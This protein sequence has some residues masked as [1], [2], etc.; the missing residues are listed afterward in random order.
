MTTLISFI[1][2]VWNL[3]SEFILHMDRHLNEWVGIMGPWF[4]LLVFV[5]VFCETGLVVTPFLPG[6]SLFFALGA[7]TSVEDARLS[8][9]LLYVLAPVAAIIGNAVNYSIGNFLGPRVFRREA[10]E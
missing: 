4:Y 1:A 2:D 6:D 8:L 5:V 7:L 9:P 10:L 3:F